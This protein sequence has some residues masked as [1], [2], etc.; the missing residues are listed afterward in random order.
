MMKF[1]ANLF[2]SLFR[3]SADRKGLT[4]ST[5]SRYLS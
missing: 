2:R 5:A 4:T 1:A 3:K